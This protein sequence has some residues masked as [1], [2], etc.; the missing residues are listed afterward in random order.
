MAYA[1]MCDDADLVTG[2][3]SAPDT[4]EEP[5]FEGDIRST[6]ERMTEY[7]NTRGVNGTARQ[8]SFNARIRGRFPG[9]GFT[10]NPELDAFVGPQH[11]A[12]WTLDETGA[13][14][15]PIPRPDDGQNY[16]WDEPNQAW[17]IAAE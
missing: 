13:W 14:Q 15:P 2:V 17:V 5:A 7:F 8:A 4:L 9:P 1:A 6:D 3:Y 11:F 12:S 10:Y 16:T